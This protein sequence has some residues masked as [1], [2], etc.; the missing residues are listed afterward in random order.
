[1]DCDTVEEDTDSAVSSAPS[2][3]SPQPYHSSSQLVPNFEYNAETKPV[4]PTPLVFHENTP[5]HTHQS[6]TESPL[7]QSPW[8]RRTP[9]IEPSYQSGENTDADDDILD[10]CTEKTDLQSE[11]TIAKRQV[12]E[13]ERALLVVSKT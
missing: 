9:Y 1:M 12:R 4:I 8:F 6:F 5:F 10:G 2:S 11:L 3:L 13:L 7:V